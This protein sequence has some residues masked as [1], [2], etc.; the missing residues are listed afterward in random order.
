MGVL[1]PGTTANAQT[2]P[3]V[4]LPAQPAETAWPTQGWPAATLDADAALRAQIDPVFER[5]KADEMGET[6]AVVVIKGGELVYERYRDGYTPDTRHIS[7]SMAK[8][9][10]AT[11]VGRAVQLGLIDSVDDPMPSGFAADDPRAQTSWRHWLQMLDGLE[12]GEYGVAEL[13]ENDVVQMSFGPG[14]FDQL[15]YARENFDLVH[16]PGTHWNYTTAGFHLIARALQ[17][18][19]PG[20]C[21]EDGADPE[22]C[23]ADPAV[24]RDWVDTVLFEP[25]GLDG[26]VEFDAHG[27]MLGGSLVYMDARDFAKFG[28]L[29]LRGGTWDGERLLPEGWVDFNRT[30]PE[31]GDSNDYG[32][33]FWLSPTESDNP[34]LT[35]LPPFDAFHAGGRAGQI[36]WVVPSEDMVVVRLGLMPD[37]PENWN[38]LFRFAQEVVAA[39]G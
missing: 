14:R 39:A 6:K 35:F 5:S 11:L 32:A 7:W 4:P 19:L 33:G 3:L 23:Q 10:T 2:S 38:A 28:Q 34:D 26:V 15:A 20:T 12:Y 37:S 36:V 1:A 24:M 27:T 18:L 8:S 13:M 25:L 31:S 29:L 22:T 16:E 21:V 30:S 9:V 17:S